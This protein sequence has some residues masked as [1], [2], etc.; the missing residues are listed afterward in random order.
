MGVIG[1][2]GSVPAVVLLMSGIGR[3]LLAVY[4]CSQVMFKVRCSLA[5]DG[6]RVSCMF[7]NL[8]FCPFICLL[9]SVSLCRFCICVF[10][11]VFLSISLCRFCIC[12]FILVFLSGFCLFVWFA[13]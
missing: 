8:L 7:F 11:L 5:V 4:I 6:I 1:L 9:L 2:C 12:V 10:I 13:G 3:A